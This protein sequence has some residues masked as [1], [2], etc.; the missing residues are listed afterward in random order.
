MAY[1]TT[2]ESTE[3]LLVT[4]GVGTG[5]TQR[6]VERAAALLAENA[7]AGNVLVLCATPQAARLFSE[8]LA[9]APTSCWAATPTCWPTTARAAGRGASRDC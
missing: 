3:A 1:E 8:R 4:G 6:L 7:A 2:S 9:E 5:K